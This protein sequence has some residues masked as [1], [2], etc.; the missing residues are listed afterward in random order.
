M[1]CDLQINLSSTVE[2]VLSHN[3]I[4]NAYYRSFL[5]S[6]SPFYYY[7]KIKMAVSVFFS[8]VCRENVIFS[9]IDHYL[10]YSFNFFMNKYSITNSSTLF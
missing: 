8:H 5:S 7:R 2:L 10:R 1:L 6:S 9:V 3:H 4:F